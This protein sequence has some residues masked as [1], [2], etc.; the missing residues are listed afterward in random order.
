MRRPPKPEDDKWHHGKVLCQIA[1]GIGLV[2]RSAA[3][4]SM[5]HLYTSQPTHATTLCLLE[6]YWRRCTPL[7][8]AIVATVASDYKKHINICADWQSE[9]AKKCENS[10]RRKKNNQPYRNQSVYLYSENECRWQLTKLSSGQLNPRVGDFALVTA[11]SVF[12][13]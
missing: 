2:T 1:I 13:V 11:L 9:K 4:C 10:K 3:S 7:K 8:A 12:N 5:M 6:L